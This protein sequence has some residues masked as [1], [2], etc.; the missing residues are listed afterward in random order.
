MSY[1]EMYVSRFPD[2]LDYSLIGQ[3]KIYH[4]IQILHQTIPDINKKMNKV[5]LITE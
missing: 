3:L 5:V 2:T 4:C 1:I